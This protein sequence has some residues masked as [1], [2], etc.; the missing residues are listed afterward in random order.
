MMDALVVCLMTDHTFSMGIGNVKLMHEG[1]PKH[2][3]IGT[4]RMKQ[5]IETEQGEKK[6]EYEKKNSG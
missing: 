1:S 4:A 6:S 3:Q 2:L 5:D